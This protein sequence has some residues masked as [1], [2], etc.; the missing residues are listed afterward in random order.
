MAQTQ[1]FTKRAQVHLKEEGTE[2]TYDDPDGSGANMFMCEIPDVP[3]TLNAQ[4]SQPNY[5]R[6][7]FLTM[8][9]VPGTVSASLTFRVPLAYSGTA[10]TAPKCD[11]VFKACGMEVTN[12]ASTSDTYTP[13]STFSGAGGLP[14][15]SYSCSILESG[16]RYAIAGAQGTFTI[17][18]TAGEIAYMDVTM[19][20]AYQAVADDALEVAVYDGGI[21]PAFLGA[22]VNLAGAQIGVTDFSFDLGNEIAFLPD[23]NVAT[24]FKGARIVGRKS[25]GSINPEASLVAT[26]D[27]FGL[28]RAGTVAS[29]TTGAV[30]GTAGHKWTFSCP[31]V[32]RG[33]PSLASADGIRHFEIPFTVGSLATAVEGTVDDVKLQFT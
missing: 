4:N 27:H 33:T 10:G 26:T 16:I 23:V 14:G 2:N 11:E 18:A 32:V 12:V 5:T 17:S 15:P 22:A 25:S 30:G 8:D 3:M 28:W 24:G 20:G 21:A 29:F 1:I 6:S 9:A 19:S 7:D 31:R 13:H